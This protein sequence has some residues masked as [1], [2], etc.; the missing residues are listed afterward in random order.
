MKI[1]SDK[2][3]LVKFVQYEKNMGFVPTMGAIHH[4]HI[5]L[6]KK[7][8][9]QCNKTIISI[10]VNKPQFNKKS[11]FKKYPRILKEDISILKKLKVDF[12]YLPIENQIYPEGH[13][14]NIKISSFS[15]KLCGKLRP[16]HLLIILKNL[17][18]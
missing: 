7:S 8:K 15:K 12:L 2:N 10:F 11:D 1:T 9:K 5:S 3:K 17:K 6:I 4:G 13:N 16:K 14:K 18:N